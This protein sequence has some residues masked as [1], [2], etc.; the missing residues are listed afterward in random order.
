MLENS[1]TPNLNITMTPEESARDKARILESFLSL[2][3]E[4]GWR[5]ETLVKAAE[6][7]DKS[8]LDVW[9]LFPEKTTDALETWNRL[10]DQQMVSKL[11]TLNLDEMRVRERIF[12]GV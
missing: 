7:V 6:S 8:S 3:G 11:K 10:L 9:A 5:E 12:W 4:E 2:A 1:P